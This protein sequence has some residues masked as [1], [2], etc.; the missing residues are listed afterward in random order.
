MVRNRSI[1]NAEYRTGHVLRAY[2][3]SSY[4]SGYAAIDSMHKY[5]FLG[6]I[7][8]PTNTFLG[9]PESENMNHCS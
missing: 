1:R 3:N 6:V 2:A 4:A 5:A 8:S 7:L 9:V